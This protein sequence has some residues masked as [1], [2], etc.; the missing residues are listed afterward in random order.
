MTRNE[1]LADTLVESLIGANS[2]EPNRLELRPFGQ[3][4][5]DCYSGAEGPE[6]GEPLIGDI[7][8][9]GKE[10]VVIVSKDSVQVIADSPEGTEMVF[11]LPTPFAQGRAIAT[12][13]SRLKSLNDLAE[14]GFTRIS[15]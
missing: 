3:G 5:H 4:D 13:L 1:K 14:L 6:G 15:C 9:D 10:A 7:S 11:D 2:P 8:V 12:S